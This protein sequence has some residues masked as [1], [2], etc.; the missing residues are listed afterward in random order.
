MTPRYQVSMRW[1]TSSGSRL[2]N[3][4]SIHSGRL[5]L[6]SAHIFHILPYGSNAVT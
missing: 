5:R 6:N 4:P 3:G 1:V 2:V